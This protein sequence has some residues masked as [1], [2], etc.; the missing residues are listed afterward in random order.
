MRAGMTQL[1]TLT[2]TVLALGSSVFAERTLYTNTQAVEDVLVVGDRLF[3]ATQGGLEQYDL[4]RR[5][6]TGLVTTEDGLPSNFVR[7][8]FTD[9]GAVLVAV[10]DGVCQ[11]GA[12]GQTT[13]RRAT[14]RSVPPERHAAASLPTPSLYR[15]A[16]VTAEATWRGERVRGTA[17]AGVWL[18]ELDL[19]PMQSICSNHIVAIQDHFLGRTWFGSFDEGLCSLDASGWQRAHGP[20]RMIN[21][22]MVAGDTLYVA[23]SEGLFAT[24]DGEVFRRVLTGN[25]AVADL[26]YDGKRQRVLAVTNT[27]LYA[28]PLTG[29]RRRPVATFRPGGARSLQSVAV[30]PTNGN[31]WLASEDRGAI[32]IAGKETTGFDALTGLPTSW[33]IEVAVVD[34][35]AYVGTLRHGVFAL[36]ANATS[37][38]EARALPAL[39]HAWTLA[40]TPRRQGGVLVGTQAGWLAVV[41]GAVRSPIAARATENPPHGSI[42]VIYEADRGA[43]WIGSEGGTLRV[44]HPED[45]AFEKTR[46]PHAALAQ[47]LQT[48]SQN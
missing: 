7:R 24:T 38:T 35:T 31:V 5:L 23:S 46:A 26:A 2:T 27:T 6:R 20:F 13:R 12:I 33:A 37:A 32:R 16:R 15:G 36:P 14:C 45:D 40:V 47:P 19:T 48:A 1:A 30:D 34:G 17:T 21:D 44:D 3:V 39:A 4:P 22:L 18:G 10:G 9:N 42:H 11:L 29:A 41:D 8:V 43:I 28:I 25:D